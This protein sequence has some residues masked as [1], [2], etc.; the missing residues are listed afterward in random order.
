MRLST[1]KPLHFFVLHIKNAIL[2]DESLVVG[3]HDVEKYISLVICVS[4][5]MFKG[6]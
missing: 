6:D 5:N 2:M 1:V 4:M 3:S